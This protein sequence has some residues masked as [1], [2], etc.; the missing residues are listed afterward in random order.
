[1]LLINSA[2]LTLME[3]KGEK[4]EIFLVNDQVFH[5]MLVR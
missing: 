2:G 5:A 4:G 3:K 1:M